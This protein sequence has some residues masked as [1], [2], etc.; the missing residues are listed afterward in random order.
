MRG[1]KKQPPCS[2]HCGQ[3][4][5][6]A[7]LLKPFSSASSYPKDTTAKGR[8]KNQ[9]QHLKPKPKSRQAPGMQFIGRSPSPLQPGSGRDRGEE[10]GSRH[11]REVIPHAPALC[12]A[13]RLPRAPLHSPRYR[14]GAGPRRPRPL[15]GNLSLPAALLTH[16][17]LCP[18][19]ELA[20]PLPFAAGAAP[21]KPRAGRAWG[22]SGEPGP[23]PGVRQWRQSPP[24]RDQL[25]PLPRTVPGRSNSAQLWSRKQGRA[26]TASR[27]LRHPEFAARP[28]QAHSVLLLPTKEKGP[29]APPSW[30]QSVSLLSAKQVSGA[31][32]GDSSWVTSH[33]SCWHPSQRPGT[34]PPGYAGSTH[35]KMDG[36]LFPRPSRGRRKTWV[37]K[38]GMEKVPLW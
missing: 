15:P 8:A 3:N 14:G 7:N 6:V 16:S 9:T 19:L 22:F 5:A 28:Q 32:R 38:K 12:K 21:S 23:W 18:R 30:C 31:Q 37:G 26:C 11:W 4:P 35:P 33:P 25:T 2:H 24:G 29:E 13:G 34:Q 20:P 1:K 10:G 36:F 27:D 17:R